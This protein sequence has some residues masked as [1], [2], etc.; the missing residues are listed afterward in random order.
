MKTILS[1]LFTFVSIQIY[2]QDT[3]TPEGKLRYRIGIIRGTKITQMPNYALSNALRDIANAAVSRVPY[4]TMAELRAGKADTARVVEINE[5][6]KSGKFIYDPTDT[7]SADDS[8]LTIRNGGRRYKRQYSGPFNAAW[9]GIVGDG[10]TDESAL[11]QKLLDNAAIKDIF[12]PLPEVSYRINS[13]T[14]RSNKTITFQDGAVVHGLG[15]LTTYQRMVNM[16]DISNVTIRGYR[17]VFKDTKT[18][19][20]GINPTPNSQR[21]L[22]LIQGCSNIVIEGIAANDSGGD[23]FYIGATT[24]QKFCQN[25][26]LINVSADNNKRQGLSIVSG[27]SVH[28][29]GSSFTGTKD[30]TPGAGIDVEPNASDEFLQDIRIT[31]CK[32]GSNEGGGLLIALNALNGSLNPVDIVVTNH[33]DYASRYGFIASPAIGTA[34]GTVIIQNSTWE[35]NG[36]HNA[37]VSNYS[38]SF[39]RIKFENCQ[40]INANEENSAAT[41]YGTAMIVFREAAMSGSTYIG[42]VEFNNCRVTETRAT[43]RVKVGILAIDYNTTANP[44]GMVKDCIIH[45][46]RFDGFTDFNKIYV[47]GEVIIRDPA[48]ALSFGVGNSTRA[49]DFYAYAPLFHNGNSTGQTLVNLADV[50]PGFPQVTFE[51]RTHN[52]LIIDPASGDNILPLSSGAGKR[53]SSDVIG[54]KVTLYKLS[55]DS[56][57]ISEI[58]GTWTVEP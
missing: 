56:W 28:V 24:T 47:K 51:I 50:Q 8:V 55:A 13:I 39:P 32:T 29:T 38:A 6:K 41:T 4:V 17:V 3:L 21:H 5:G 31:D 36:L 14:I 42:N 16:V 25:V 45:N 20:P 2:S 35:T 33:H 57:I 58:T 7:S 11:W 43:K 9:M 30:D 46:A 1:I 54:S 18:A 27:K 15:L 40:G 37:L 22:F 10:T 26:K 19:Y 23:G 53:I 34:Y 44:S 49:Y 48:G 12:F 52:L